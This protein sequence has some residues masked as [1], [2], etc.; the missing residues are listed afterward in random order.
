MLQR[1]YRRSRDLGDRDGARL[2]T[3]IQASLLIAIVSGSFLSEQLTV[4]FWLFGALA[5]SV[6]LLFEPEPVV[7][8][9]AAA[10]A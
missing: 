5:V 7:A 2:A 8:T 1:A 10:P 6:G 9:P 4:P 3:A